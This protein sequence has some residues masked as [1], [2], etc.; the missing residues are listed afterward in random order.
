MVTQRYCIFDQNS[1]YWTNDTTKPN[2]LIRGNSSFLYPLG[3]QRYKSKARP[4]LVLRSTIGVVVSVLAFVLFNS[5]CVADSCGRVCCAGDFLPFGYCFLYPGVGL[6]FWSKSCSTW[7]PLEWWGLFISLS[8][9]LGGMGSHLLQWIV[10][11]RGFVSIYWI[12][13]RDCPEQV[14]LSSII[15]QIFSFYKLSINYHEKL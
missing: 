13:Q 14:L 15:F 10:L 3:E 9:M 2:E 12:V 7:F 4:K 6:L 1:R 8:L 5:L 11:D